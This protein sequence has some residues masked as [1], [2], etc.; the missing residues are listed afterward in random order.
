[1]INREVFIIHLEQEDYLSSIRLGAVLVEDMF[2][3][4]G[5]DDLVLSETCYNVAISNRIVGYELYNS[6]LETVNSGSQDKDE[7]KQAIENANSDIN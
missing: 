1:M 4:L 7:L 5:V 3:T 6:V 2:N